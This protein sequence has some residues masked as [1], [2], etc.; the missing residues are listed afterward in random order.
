MGCSPERFGCKAFGPSMATSFPWATRQMC[1]AVLPVAILLPLHLR[2]DAAGP[3]EAINRRHLGNNTHHTETE[4]LGLVISKPLRFYNLYC[5]HQF[6][7]GA[8]SG[9][10]TASSGH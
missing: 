6:L 4:E 3:V 7:G 1:E 10:L 5:L 2:C 8:A 9:E